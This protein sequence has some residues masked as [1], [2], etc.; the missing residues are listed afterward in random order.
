MSVVTI[1]FKYFF[2]FL[3][4][5]LYQHIKI[6]YKYKKIKFNQYPFKTQ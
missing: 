3:K 5:F 6:I 4:L 2:I 1:F